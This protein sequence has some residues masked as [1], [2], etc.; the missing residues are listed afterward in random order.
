MAGVRDQKKKQ[1]R[2]AILKAAVKLFSRQGYEQ[3][4]IDQL[5]RAA[6]IGKGTVYSYFQ[7][8]SEIF[9]AFCEEQ[10]EFINRELAARSNP[11]APLLQQLLTFFQ[12]EFRFVSRNREFGRI[13]LRET[14]FPKDFTGERA[15]QLDDKYIDILIPIF[16]QAQARGELRTDLELI[17]V[18]GHFYALYIMTV[19]AWY[20]GRLHTEEDVAMGMELLFEQALRGLAPI[21]AR[22]AAAHGAGK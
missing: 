18:T 3:T 17:V 20:M 6:G 1:T 22:E 19:S 13:F 14:V 21:T 4:S 5:A 16:K 7:T 11:E 15:R 12:G 10:L 8:K 9:L 2:A